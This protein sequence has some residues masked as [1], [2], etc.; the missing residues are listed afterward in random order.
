MIAPHT[1]IGGRYRVVKAL[2]GGGMK[3]VYL[4]EDLR[5][6]AR[7]CALAEMVDTF[8]SIEAQKEAISA[9]Q[10]EADMLA[11]LNNEHIPRV[12]DRFSEGNHHFLV[13]EYIDGTT[14][15]DRI[16]QQGG[17][18]PPQEVVDVALQ[19]LD[20]LDY[21]HHLQPPVIYRD[22]KPSNIMVTADSR[23]KLIDFGIARHFQ[24]LSNATMIG[25][26]GYAP[27]EQYRGKVETRSDIYALGATMHHAI[28][29]RDPAAEP[30]FSF[31]PLLKLCPDL[32]P[33]LAAAIDQALAYDVV[34][35]LPDAA[36]FKNRLLDIKHNLASAG[37]NGQGLGN[38]TT[39]TQLKL[40]LGELTTDPTTNQA[41]GNQAQVRLS[42]HASAS[43]P[44]APTVL[45]A[46]TEV[47]CPQCTRRIPA[48]SRFCSY[49][50]SDL[51]L[52]SPLPRPAA[53]TDETVLLSG[54]HLPES[55]RNTVLGSNP[56]LNTSP[57]T[58]RR[59]GLRRPFLVLALIFAAGFIA[60]ELIKSISRTDDP[61]PPGYSTGSTDGGEAMPR[62]HAAIPPGEYPGS[63]DYGFAP[64]RS[65]LAALRARL[66]AQGYSAVKFRLDGDTLVLYGSVPTDYDRLMVQAICIATVG[67]TP[68]SDDLTISGNDPEG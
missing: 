26:Q 32:E 10:R 66:D 30:P 2:G 59:N 57:R 45:S 48:D 55:L 17:K 38:H 28:S 41:A 18:L 25:T 12:F 53:A 43:M 67:L 36:E 15:E 19:V 34:S 8:T 44:A 5:L 60:A 20:T 35:R 27:P 51:R 54:S 64:G 9:F 29:G 14:L 49:C 1:I 65:R 63:S 3:L 68:F 58:R 24:P 39:R 6:A 50:A 46:T 47:S 40:P 4:A 62:A 52:I 56:S 16:K 23:A 42:P 31:P 33:R 13:M 37:G 61:M 21:L 7:N 22:L 11:Q